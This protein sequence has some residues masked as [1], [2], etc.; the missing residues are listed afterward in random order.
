MAVAGKRRVR[1]E[2]RQQSARHSSFEVV[3][4]VAPV[5]LHGGTSGPV[6]ARGG[7]GGAARARLNPLQHARKRPRAEALVWRKLGI[8]ESL[9][10]AYYRAQP[11]LGLDDSAE[12][13]RFARAIHEP[14]PAAFRFHPR[15]PAAER[16]RA[17]RALCR[18]GARELTWLP[19]RAGW[20][21]ALHELSPDARAAAKH[22]LLACSARG[23]LCRQEAVSMLPV[24]LLAPRPG[25]RVVDLCAAPGSKTM[26]LLEA[27]GAPFPAQRASADIA[28]GNEGPGEERAGLDGSAD[29]AAG[30]ERPGEE[31]A[32]LD[33]SDVQN[34]CGRDAARGASLLV[35]NDAHPLRV[36]AL[37][38]ALSRHGGRADGAAGAA[39]M[40]SC[41]LAQDFPTPSFRTAG[42][43]LSP[44]GEQK[45]GLAQKNLSAPQRGE[46]TLG[47]C[48]GVGF[49]CV[50][51]DV[52]CSGD[53]TSRKDRRAVTDWSPAVGSALHATQLQILRRALHLASARGGR[54]VYSTCSLNPAEDEAVVAAALAE[55]RA[56]GAHTQVRRAPLGGGTAGARDAAVAGPAASAR[57]PANGRAPAGVS[58]QDA[59]SRDATC[60]ADFELGKCARLLPHSSGGGGFFL[61][62]FT[63]NRAS[64]P[65]QSPAPA[66]PWPAVGPAVTARVSGGPG[67]RVSGVRTGG[68]A[69]PARLVPALPLAIAAGLSGAALHAACGFALMAPEGSDVCQPPAL[70]HDLWGSAHTPRAE[71]AG[72]PARAGATACGGPPAHL[73]L[74]P[75]AAVLASAGLE[76]CA[77]HVVHAGPKAFALR[78]D[79]DC[80]AG[81]PVGTAAGARWRYDVLVCALPELQGRAALGGGCA[82]RRLALRTS[83]L[84]ALLKV[85]RLSTEA[86]SA[87]TAAAL[88][89]LCAPRDGAG[90]G[91]GSAGGAAWWTGPLLVSAVGDAP[92]T[93]RRCSHSSAMLLPCFLDC[94]LGHGAESGMEGANGTEGAEL[95]LSEQVAADAQLRSSY[96]ERVRALHA[97][98]QRKRAVLQA[99]TRVKGDE[100]GRGAKASG[101]SGNASAHA[102]RKGSARGASEGQSHAHSLDT[103]G[104]RARAREDKPRAEAACAGRKRAERGGR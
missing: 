37:A 64:E 76:P 70:I 1:H 88:D 85:G 83:E 7:A 68:V 47:V 74:A 63:V 102:Q 25:E 9:F 6:V 57:A 30:N 104:K 72:P 90:A 81:R 54:V 28:A 59:G 13:A 49:D 34:A 60:A 100:G 71:R 50:L 65:A 8:G 36:A 80:A 26:Q 53:G 23:V 67:G 62:L 35:A 17:E 78:T 79:G 101:L 55:S 61:A 95:L 4:V 97:Q 42:D 3:P 48:D 29:I 66:T 75:P 98:L 69:A 92:V 94:T 103:K 58:L 20:E 44:P 93:P 46:S 5:V 87:R 21:L 38:E 82:L 14:L 32:G 33:G 31:R 41:G 16:E 11:G 56:A 18:L 43:E 39:L 77:L 15:A 22:E 73:H 51:A 24:L 40:L 96:A 27:L 86:L 99:R 10:C 84:W 19:D 89:V 12:F 91:G 52:P 45:P 2:P